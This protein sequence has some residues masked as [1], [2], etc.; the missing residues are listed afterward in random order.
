MIAKY[1]WATGSILIALLGIV[2]LYYTFFTNVFSSRNGKLIEDM[3]A[4]SPILSQKITMWK[5]WIGFNGSHS[6][7]VI[8]IGLMNLYLAFYYFSVLQSDHL[9]FVFN[10]LTIGFYI[11]LAKKYW[12]NIPLIGLS[13]TM[14]CYIT[15]YILTMLNK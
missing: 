7:G 6:S 10:I 4:N 1:L 9:F 5:A 11:W 2:H 13:I 14:A 12:F 15:S 3:Q 8:F